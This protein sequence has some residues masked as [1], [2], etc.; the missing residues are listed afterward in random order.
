MILWS[1]EHT[2]KANQQFLYGNVGDISLG[3]A[4]IYLS[5]SF[6]QYSEF[7]KFT[8]WPRGCEIFFHAREF[9]C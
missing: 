9:F 8:T 7:L 6:R 4:S 3:R 2:H 1:N 5:A